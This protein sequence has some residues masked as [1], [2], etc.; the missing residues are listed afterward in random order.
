MRA[1]ATLPP[2]FARFGQIGGAL[3]FAVYEEA[4]G[5]EAEALEA[6]ARTIP[7]LDRAALQSLGS[8]C[9]DELTFL[10]DWYDPETGSLLRRGQLTTRDGR[11]LV[12]PKLADLAGLH[13]VSASGEVPDPG[14]GGQF[15]YAFSFTP[16]GLDTA[17]EEVQQLFSAI[18]SFILPPGLGH[19]TL[20]WSSP[21]L[22]EVSELFAAGMEWWGVFLFTVYV[23]ALRRLTVIAGSTSD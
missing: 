16:Y 10:G 22:P 18:T 5:D 4:G 8:R 23:P 14:S 21:R 7:D 20:D 3:G 17:P 19:L 2:E 12:D 13:V 9:I 15:A 1:V 11:K 6:I